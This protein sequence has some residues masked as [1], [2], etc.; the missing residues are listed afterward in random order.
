[1]VNKLQMLNSFL[2]STVKNYHTVVKIGNNGCCLFKQPNSCRFKGSSQSRNFSTKPIKSL[3][4]NIKNINPNFVSGFTDAEGSFYVSIYKDKNLKTGWRIQAWFSLGLHYKDSN[5]LNSIKLGFLGVGNIYLNK[6]GTLIYSIGSLKDLINII[7]PHFEKYPLL[8]QKRSDF[9]FLK[10]IVELMNRKEHL[11]ISGLRKILSIRASMNN[12]LTKVLE[13]SFPGISPVPRPTVSDQK[14][15]EPNWLAGFSSG[16]SCFDIK[17]RKSETHKTGT[18]VILRFKISQHG[19]DKILLG[20][21]VN[22]FKCGYLQ[23]TGDNVEFTVTK[24]NDIN[25][26]IIPFLKKFPIQGVKLEDFKDFCRVAELIKEKAHLTPEGLKQ[27]IN[28][29]E[30][31]NT[32]RKWDSNLP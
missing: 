21:I 31:M 20:L 25:N 15:Q 16:D 32:G 19:R 26:I 8:T 18:Q 10:M 30:G 28:I 17:I 3:S 14:I 23:T 7:I 1:M 13:E 12:G 22:Y 6:N 27:I 24:F 29:K 5:L 2:V 4:S 9:E 11:T